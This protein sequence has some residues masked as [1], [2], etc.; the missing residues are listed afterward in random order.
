MLRTKLDITRIDECA[1]TM[2]GFFKKNCK[3]FSVEEQLHALIQLTT[4]AMYEA[5]SE[6]VLVEYPQCTYVVGCINHKSKCNL[7]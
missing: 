2:Q 6:S 1:L 3:E 5:N 4:S 7:P